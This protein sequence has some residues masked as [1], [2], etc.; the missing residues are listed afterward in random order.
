MKASA[1][2]ISMILI[3]VPLAGCSGTD[4]EV[5]VDL[6]NEDINDLIDENLEDVMN[7]TTVVVFQE[8]HNN[9][10]V[11]NHNLY[12]NNTTN[13][14]NSQANNNTTNVDN[15]QA[16]NSTYNYNGT[17]GALSVFRMI[18]NWSDVIG[19]TENMSENNFTVEYNYFDY[20]TNEERSDIFTLPCSNYYDAPNPGSDTTLAP[21]WTDG[22]GDGTPDNYQE[23][24]D[25][26][27][28]VHN[29]TIRDLLFDVAFY[30]EVESACRVPDG[31]YIDRYIDATEEYYLGSGG[32]GMNM[33]SVHDYSNAP[34][35]YEMTIPDG[36]AI[37]IAQINSMHYYSYYSDGGLW[38]GSQWEYGTQEI[39]WTVNSFDQ[40]LFGTNCGELSM[41]VRHNK[42]DNYD[43]GCGNLYGGWGEI[44]LD[45][46]VIS[47]VYH[48]SMFVFT[49][50]YELVPVTNL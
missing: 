47:S 33:W 22:D 15:S 31:D 38:G 24:W 11:I 16:S 30:Q 32:T 35:F 7:N 21:Y 46:Q 49:M 34:V 1:L 50:Y 39:F 19:V 4:T 12:S 10:T 48:D 6:S 45:F 14:D 28:Y 27:D 26:W 3:L 29:N 44:E 5:N 41:F 20:D 40:G 36:Y 13:V 42:V 8:Y 17:N 25:W 43:T 23:Y 9:T 18:W 37:R 2:A